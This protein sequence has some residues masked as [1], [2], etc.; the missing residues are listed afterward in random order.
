[1]P[2]PTAG[3]QDAAVRVLDAIVG[4]MARASR[5]RSPTAKEIAIHDR[6]A[7][8]IANCRASVDVCHGLP[9]VMLMR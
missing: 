3:V 9:A 8:C 5:N 7:S 4:L 6:V 2:L 1:M